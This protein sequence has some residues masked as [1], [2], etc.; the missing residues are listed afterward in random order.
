MRRAW[1]ERRGWK[2]VACAAV[3]GCSVV[4]LSAAPAAAWP[5][6]LRPSS[7]ELKTGYGWQYTNH[8]RPTNFQLHLLLPSV[9]IPLSGVMGPSW[10]RGRW[11]WNPEL[12]VAIF[13]HPYVRP[14]FGFTPLQ[15]RYELEPIGRFHPYGLLGAGVLHSRINRGET[16]ARTN[17]NLQAGLGIRYALTARTGLMVEYRHIHISNSGLEEHNTGLNTHTVLA[18]LSGDF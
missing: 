6:W 3:V 10:L 4:A 5:A 8:K 9:V 17:F 18:G 2:A 15:F 16:G 14:M 12:L 13:S 11:T 1:R 7:W